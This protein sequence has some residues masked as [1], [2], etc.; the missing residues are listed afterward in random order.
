MPDGRLA[1]GTR[2]GDVYF[3]DGVDST[4]AQPKY[5]LFATGL[6]EIFGLAWHNGALRVTQA[7]IPKMRETGGGSIVMINTMSMRVVNPTFTAYAAGKAALHA[8]TQGMA[9]E[10]G[11]DQ[12]RVNS[13][14]PGYIWGEAVERLF[15]HQVKKEGITKEQAYARVAANIPL[16]RIPEPDEI[17]AV[18]TFLLGPDAG[19]VHGSIVY[20]D[21]GGDA[22]VRP[23]GF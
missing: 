20:A 4:P 16:G 18:I 2:R 7:T 8:A 14:M 3:I 1:V 12:I 19:Y 6:D 9:R 22:A 10:L 17:A 21:G 13:V 23:D 15:D 5:H 11:K